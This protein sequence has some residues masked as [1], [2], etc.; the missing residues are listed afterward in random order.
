MNV[1]TN[2]SQLRKAYGLS[3]QDI[4]D[5]ISVKR[6]TVVAIEQGKRDLTSQELISLADKLGV[7]LQDLLTQEMPDIGKYREMLIEAVRVSTLDGQPLPK[8]KLAKLLYLADFAWFYDHLEPMSGMKYRRL[9]YGPVPDQYFRIVDELFLEGKISIDALSGG[10][11][12]ISLSR[13]GN[14]SRPQHLRSAELALIRDVADKWRESN[15][16]EIVD[17][18]HTQLPWQICRPNEFIPYE[19][20]TQEEK[21]NVY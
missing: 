6:T 19:L 5:A 21:A 18:T 3:Q 1:V 7:D 4:A 12:L 20:I 9:E 16:E 13:T 11:Q 14:M 8:T 15:V 2:L 10:A 17:F